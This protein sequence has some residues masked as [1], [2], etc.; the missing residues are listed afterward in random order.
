MEPLSLDDGITSCDATGLHNHYF[1]WL[2]AIPFCGW[3]MPPS[4]QFWLGE[5][6][7]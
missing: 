4:G 2:H 6:P 5:D 7:P 3:T 1:Q